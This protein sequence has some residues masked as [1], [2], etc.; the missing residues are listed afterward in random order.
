[1]KVITESMMSVTTRAT[2]RS[3]AK[4]GEAAETRRP[5]VERNPKAEGRIDQLLD[6]PVIG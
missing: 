4:R 5:K 3:P 1:M 6:D 2:P